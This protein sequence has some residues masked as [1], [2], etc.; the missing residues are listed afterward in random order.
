MVWGEGEVRDALLIW[1][2]LGLHSRGPRE[3]LRNVNAEPSSL[4]A[5][6]GDASPQAP[7]RLG[8]LRVTDPTPD[9]LRLSWTVP[10]GHFDSFVV[11]FK[12]RDGPRMVPVGGHER[13]VTITPL[14][15]SRTY[16]FL[17]YGLLGKRR[18]G[19]LSAD[20]TTGEAAAAAL[21]AGKVPGSLQAGLP[22][23]SP[24]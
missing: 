21:A 3:S 2:V 24:L 18:H 20:G 8:E 4:P 6:H 9:S 14:D 22:R 5:V 1:A 19:P 23:P 7:P 10:E 15:S 11:Q 16:R 17:L 12:D 13:S